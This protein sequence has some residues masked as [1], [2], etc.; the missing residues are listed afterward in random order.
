ML[1]RLVLCMVQRPEC[2]RMLH[3]VWQLMHL[4]Y[5]L[6]RFRIAI[7]DSECQRY[8]YYDLVRGSPLTSTLA[9]LLSNQARPGLVFQ[10][11]IPMRI[12][13]GIPR[14][15]AAIGAGQPPF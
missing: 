10:S 11:A 15:G 13:T 3:D 8:V 4:P 5:R 12:R 1:L 2:S 6:P 7:A 14:L 9:D